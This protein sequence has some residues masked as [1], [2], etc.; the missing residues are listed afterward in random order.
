[1]NILEPE[2]ERSLSQSNFQKISIALAQVFNKLS[3]LDSK[4]TNGKILNFRKRKEIDAN[5]QSKENTNPKEDKKIVREIMTSRKDTFTINIED[6]VDSILDSLAN[7]NHTKIPVYEKNIDNIIGILNIGDLAIKSKEKELNNMDL[8]NLLSKPK[9][10]PETKN[11]NE[12]YDSI[13]SQDETLFILVDEYG[14]FS[15]IITMDDLIYEVKG[16]TDEIDLKSSRITKID[17]NNFI[18]KGFLSISDFNEVFGVDIEQGDYD[19]LN[20]YIVDTLGQIPSEN[21]NIEINLGDLI[22]K[23]L[24]VNNRRIEEIQVSIEN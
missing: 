12:L 20:G 8:R 5:D 22:L 24:K 3:D 15:G 19:T 9:Y 6:N 16:A 10:L 21:E 2:P 23:S 18:V 17:E 14:G 13:K 11:V 1:M 7:T 4:N